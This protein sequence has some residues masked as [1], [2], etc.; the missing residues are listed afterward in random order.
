MVDYT[1]LYNAGRS[2]VRKWNHSNYSESIR[3]I[4]GLVCS[5]EGF[6]PFVNGMRDAGNVETGFVPMSR[7]SNVNQKGVRRTY[8]LAKTPTFR[9]MV[10][11]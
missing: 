1:I 10:I 9:P 2:L 11:E 5:I 3:I 4:E 7:M 6:V 8:Q